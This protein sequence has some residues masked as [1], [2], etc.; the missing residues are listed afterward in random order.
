MNFT[1]K[2]EPNNSTEI[3]SHNCN[4]INYGLVLQV[5]QMSSLGSTLNAQPTFHN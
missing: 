4:I 3:P 1:D 2:L 5:I